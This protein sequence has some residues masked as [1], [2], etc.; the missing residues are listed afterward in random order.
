MQET[1][2]KCCKLPNDSNTNTSV[3]TVYLPIYSDI[4]APLFVSLAILG[5]VSLLTFLLFIAYNNILHKSIV[6][7]ARVTWFLVDLIQ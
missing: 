5:S 7:G 3:P 1:Q 6:K 2:N 4:F